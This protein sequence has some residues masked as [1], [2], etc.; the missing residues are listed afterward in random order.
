LRPIAF[1][2]RG[3]DLIGDPREQVMPGT[4][5]VGSFFP[6][7]SPHVLTQTTTTTAVQEGITL[8]IAQ[9]RPAASLP[10]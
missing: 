5:G 4:S 2:Q 9:E 7:M 8:G 10:E 6:L 1:P 3:R